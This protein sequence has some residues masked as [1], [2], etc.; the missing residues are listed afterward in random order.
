[1]GVGFSGV[2]SGDFRPEAGANYYCAF[3]RAG[4]IIPEIQFCG[5]SEFAV[6]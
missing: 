1:V 5:F 4:Y 3:A 2:S 6:G